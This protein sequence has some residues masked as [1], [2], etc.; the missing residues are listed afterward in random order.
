MIKKIFFLNIVF[1]AFFFGQEA[2]AYQIEKTQ[3]K[4][5]D[6][7]IVHPAKVDF[8]IRP[9]QI[10][11]FDLIVANRLGR[12][13]E[14]FIKEEHYKD[15]NLPIIEPEWLEIETRNFSLGNL[16]KITLKVKVAVPEGVELGGYYLALVV[17]TEKKMHQEINASRIGLV[18][19]IKIPLLS[20]VGDV[21]PSEN[22]SVDFGARKFFFLTGPI[23]FSTKVFNQSKV[24]LNIHGEVSIFNFLGIKTAQLPFSLG[25]VLP[26]KEAA[27]ETS[28]LKKFP[29]GPYWAKVNVWYG[30]QGQI[31][32]EAFF[33][34]FPIHLLL[35]LLFLIWLAARIAK[36]Y[37]VNFI[38]EKKKKNESQGGKN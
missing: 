21:A 11:E 17:G 30:K 25:T 6:R 26:G 35:I 2:G 20:R 31:Q 37:Q 32:K 34:V 13:A 28:W 15:P 16:E 1:L 12:G 22:I 23:V 8:E 5:E 10:L 29:L 27:V 3:D 4:T 36:K 7:F 33:L 19:Q 14:F 38:I 9:G 24:H 18:S